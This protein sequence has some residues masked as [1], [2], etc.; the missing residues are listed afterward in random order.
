TIPMPATT[1]S[2]GRISPFLVRTRSTRFP[3]SNATTPSSGTRRTPLS[4]WMSAKTWPTSSPRTR[5]SGTRW[6]STAATSTPSCLNDAA[7]AHVV[8][9]RRRA[10]GDEKPKPGDAGGG[11]PG[12]GSRV[13]IAIR[14]GAQREAALGGG[15]RHGKRLVASAGGYEQAI[16]GHGIAMLHDDHF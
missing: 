1:R 10:P 7:P 14:D 11:R 2:H 6:P 3:P 8:P 15:A 12:R 5:A 4:W 9:H 13:S 16:V